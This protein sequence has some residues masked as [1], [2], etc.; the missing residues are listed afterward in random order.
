MNKETYL[1]ECGCGQPTRIS[2]KTDRYHGHVKGQPLRYIHGHTHRWRPTNHIEQ[3]CGYETLC[4]VWQGRTD[5]LGYGRL[6]Q[7]R[8]AHRA[9]YRML[10]G[11]IP[12]DLELDHLCRNPT[13]VNPAHMEPVTHA[14]NLRRGAGTKLTTEQVCRIRRLLDMGV[15]KASIARLFTISPQTIHDID[16]CRSW[17]AA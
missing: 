7:S 12:D 14:E 11:P 2:E 9:Y 16:K 13:C 5:E 17:T 10:R 8:L 3:D 6:G 4:W 1:C 15:V